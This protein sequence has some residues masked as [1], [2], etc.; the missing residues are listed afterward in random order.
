MAFH[1]VI[2]CGSSASAAGV[3]LFA[4]VFAV[5]AI[6]LALRT[7]LPEASRVGRFV[8]MAFPVASAG[9]I[10]V[11]GVWIDLLDPLAAFAIAY[12]ALSAGA[13]A[14]GVRVYRR[15]DRVRRVEPPAD[16]AERERYRRSA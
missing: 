4:L 16:A 9:S 2:A 12:A 1:P 10:L 6:L 11:I 8:R 14:L 13:A 3:A 15:L 5:P 7:C